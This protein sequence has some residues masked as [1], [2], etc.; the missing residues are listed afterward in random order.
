MKKDTKM[1]YELKAEIIQAA[2]HP[3]RLAVI[4][5]LAEGEQC[6]CDIVK[7]IGAQR[8]NVSRHLALMLRAG[9]LQ[10]RKDGLKVIYS[11]KTPC[12]VKFLDCVEQALKEKMKTQSRLLK[13]LG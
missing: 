13:K 6:V 10:S 12:I 1:L 5:F 7:H 4:D 2:A 9:L 11:L 3:I 8:S